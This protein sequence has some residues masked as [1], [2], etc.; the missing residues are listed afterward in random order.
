MPDE[1]HL[2]QGLVER[3]RCGGVHLLADLD[4][5]VAVVVTR[6]VVLVAGGLICL[7]GVLDD[8]FELDALIKL[9]KW[10]VMAPDAAALSPDKALPAEI[11]KKLDALAIWVEASH[12][13]MKILKRPEKRWAHG[14]IPV[15]PAT[16]VDGESKRDLCHGVEV[17]ILGTAKGRALITDA[18]PGAGTLT[19]ML[20]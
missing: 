4:R 2:L 15:F 6:V 18:D 1:L 12:V 19:V 9:A 7:L 3:H 17:W 5:R 11:V 13:A 16:K 14:R 10:E 20:E 8:K